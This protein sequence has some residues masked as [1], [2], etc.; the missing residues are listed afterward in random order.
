MVRDRV[1]VELPTAQAAV[2]REYQSNNLLFA[3]IVA[4]QWT[5]SDSLPVKKGPLHLAAQDKKSINSP[6]NGRMVISAIDK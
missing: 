3:R 5:R 4:L 2:Y 6:S 1:P